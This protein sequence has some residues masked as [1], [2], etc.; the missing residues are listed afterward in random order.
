MQPAMKRATAAAPAPFAGFADASGRFFKALA[1]NQRRDWFT[2]HRAE[3]EEGWRAPMHALLA[4]VRTRVQ[5]LFPRE[6]VSLPKVFR[7]YRDVR[8]SKDKSPYKTHIGGYVAIGGGKGGPFGAAVPYLH[9]GAGEVFVAAG[10]Y[11]MDPTQ[12]ADFRA[13]VADDSRG[14]KLV[15]LL[16]RLARAGFT[17]GSYDQLARAPRGFDPEHPRADLLKRKG[18]I[19]SFPALPRRLLVSPK[20]ADWLV[21]HTKRTVPLIDWL[22]AV[23]L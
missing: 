10:Q 4:E 18:L 15:A 22:A 11:M 3:Y 1:R 2:S 16:A 23:S 14:G 9:I 21:A 7:I 12:L 13:A 20:L 6:E 19:V 8:F 17:V 5:P